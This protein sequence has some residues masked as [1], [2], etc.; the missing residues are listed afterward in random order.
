MRP[1]HRLQVDGDT[2]LWRRLTTPEWI[3]PNSDGTKRVSSAAFKGHENDLELSRHIASL[4]TLDWVFNSPPESLAVAEIFARDPQGLGL[5]VE[6][7]PDGD[8]NSHAVIH[9]NPIYGTRKKHA[10]K[11]ASQATLRESPAVE[12]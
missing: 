11:M 3:A 12:G 5:I 9:L 2:L 10:K 1:E 7:K 8:D 6:H 4:T